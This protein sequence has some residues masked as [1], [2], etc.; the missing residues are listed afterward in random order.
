VRQFKLQ[1][2][3]QPFSRCMICNGLLEPVS[4]E[5]VYTQLEPN[6][7]TYFEEFW[8][9]TQCRRIYWKGSHYE[10]MQALLENVNR[11]TA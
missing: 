7:A 2:K 6:T 9:C 4:K 8:Q 1:E 5:T 11:A 10:R 3:F